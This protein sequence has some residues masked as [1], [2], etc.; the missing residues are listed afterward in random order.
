MLEESYS[1]GT[2]AL[3]R[4]DVLAPEA[5]LGGRPL[6]NVG[7]EGVLDRLHMGLVESGAVDSPVLTAVLWANT[8]G[9][10][11]IVGFRVPDLTT[12]RI[13]SIGAQVVTGAGAPARTGTTLALGLATLPN[14]PNPPTG[15]GAGVNIVTP[16]YVTYYTTP[17]GRP[18]GNLG[19]CDP[20]SWDGSMVVRGP[21]T[22]LVCTLN[23]AGGDVVHLAVTYVEWPGKGVPPA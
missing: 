23:E 18:A 17:L 3:D 10:E 12:W 19:R 21:D 15:V 4:I 14:I 5:I 2:R 6:R 1:P 13:L 9:A 22:Y 8:T 16:D 7:A 11:Q 20:V